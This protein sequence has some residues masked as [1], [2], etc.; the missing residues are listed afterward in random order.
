MGAGCMV[1]VACDDFLQT[2]EE[3]SNGRIRGVVVLTAANA[4]QQEEE[5]FSDAQ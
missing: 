5:A 4:T 1:V 2:A 3:A